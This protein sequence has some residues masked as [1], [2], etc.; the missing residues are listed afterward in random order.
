M[1][2]YRS[3]VK[4]EGRARTGLGARV[5]TSLLEGL[6]DFQFELL[7]AYLNEHEIPPVRPEKIGA[8]AFLSAPDGVYRTTDSYPAIAMTPLGKLA[9]LLGMPELKEI[10]DADRAYEVRDT[11]Y[12]LLSEKL[13]AQSTAHWLSILQPADIWCAEVMDWPQLFASE[14]L[15]RLGMIQELTGPNG[16]LRTT[17]PRNRPAYGGNWREVWAVGVAIPTPDH[18]PG[19]KQRAT[20]GATHGAPPAWH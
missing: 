14:G 5:D 19:V 4:K 6:I 11:V 13:A 16:P 15:K 9:E 20:T 18:K 10:D 2:R 3:S 17:R 8:H 12:A 7:T 1:F